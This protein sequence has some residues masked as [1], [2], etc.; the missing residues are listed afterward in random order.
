MNKYNHSVLLNLEKCKGCT[1]CL[2]RCPT[3]AIR[4]RDGHAQIN[5]ERCIDCGE[6]IR[7]CPYKAKTA[8][9][10]KL[11]SVMNYKWKIALPAP[12]LYGQFDNLD[13]IDY[14]LQGLLDIGFDDVYEV[15]RA[16]EIVSEYTRHYLKT[17]A[18]K[19]P[20]ISSACPVVVRLIS[21]RFPYLC[22]NIMPIMSPMEIAGIKAKERALLEH[23]DLKEEDIC[24]V[25]ISPCPAK[26]SYIKNGFYSVKGCV[27]FVLSMNEIYFEL[28]SVMK[29]QHIPKTSSKTG[30]IGIS[31]ASTGGEAT[32]LFNDRYLAADGIENVIKVLDQLETGN[33]P[34]LEFVELNAC[35][36]GCVGG[37]LTVEN[38]FIA[39]ARL[40]NLRRY[41]PISCNRIENYHAKSDCFVPDE[42]LVKEA[43][44]YN[45]VS[46]LSSDRTEA[47]R[48]LAEIE[49]IASRLPCLDCGSCGAPTCH[50]F[51]E[52]IVKGDAHE[53]E[54][55]IKMREKIKQLPE[56]EGCF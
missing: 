5:S 16:A 18:I 22:N 43:V 52:D 15:A 42:I 51:A 11:D 45:P 37:V 25:F 54:C 21:M 24:T 38:P 33:F 14:V 6:C 49:D 19:R 32:S 27:D 29:K 40:Q 30:V 41:L 50:T 23:P 1:N 46:A 48:K 12:S 34:D 36:S 10:D 9:F 4:V 7:V 53:I 39:K 26:I 3:E 8:V 35:T 56:S 20:V 2:K 17:P 28:L 44:T 13:D 55:I 47:M 31:W